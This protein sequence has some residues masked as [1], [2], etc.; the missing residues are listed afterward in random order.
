MP[1]SM[2][3]VG[4][5]QVHFLSAQISGLLD[6]SVTAQATVVCEKGVFPGKNTHLLLLS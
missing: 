1:V 6:Y 2:V 4:K 5:N 3:V